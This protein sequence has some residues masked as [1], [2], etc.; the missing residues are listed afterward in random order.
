MNRWMIH[1]CDVLLV[2]LVMTVFSITGAWSQ[3]AIAG[4]SLLSLEACINMAMERNHSMVIA[5]NTLQMAENNVTAAPFLPTLDVTSVQSASNLSTSTY[6]ADGDLVGGQNRTNTWRTNLTLNWTLFDGLGMFATSEKQRVMLE[7]GRYRYIAVA[8]NLVKELSEQ[9][10]YIITLQNQVNLLQELVSISQ[11]RYQQALTRYR[12]GADSGLEYKQAGI[13]LNSD[14]SSLLLQR[15]LLKNAYIELNRLM[16]VPL[17]CRYVIEDAIVPVPQLDLT[18]LM[19]LA[20]EQNTSLLSIKTGERVALLDTRL[21]KA[22]RLPVLRASAG[23]G[24]NFSQSP[25]LP[26]KYDQSNGLNAGLTVSLPLFRG[27]EINRKV[28]NARLEAANANLELASVRQQVESEL[29]QLY[30]VYVNNL[31]MIDFEEESREAASMNLEAAMEKY[32]L[33]SLAGI[34]FRDYQLSY[35]NASDRKLKALYQT[36]ISEITLRLLAGELFARST[37]RDRPGR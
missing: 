17:S 21:A 27:F 9:Y 23:Y 14:S 16:N 6:E 28:A 5:S 12:I 8:E 36:K 37:P 7:Q 29:L 18:E 35:L 10:Y 19:A 15:E 25:F 13:Y 22:E 26:A 31:R 20:L 2:W 32:R 33:G 4:D 1:R 34:E 30:N 3:A 24:L 11:E